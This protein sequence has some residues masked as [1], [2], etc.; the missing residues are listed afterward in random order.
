MI[1]LKKL[2]EHKAK[3]SCFK[4]LLILTNSCSHCYF[5]LLSSLTCTSSTFLFSYWAERLG[6]W[7]VQHWPWAAPASMQVCALR[8]G[9]RTRQMCSHTLQNKNAP[10][11]EHSLHFWLSFLTSRDESGFC[12]LVC[13]IISFRRV[14]LEFISCSNCAKSRQTLWPQDPDSFNL[15]CRDA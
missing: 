3:F 8:G 12:W 6:E 7:W 15:F 5:S 2:A 13:C 10:M 11:L 1:Y 4:T 14:L 9:C